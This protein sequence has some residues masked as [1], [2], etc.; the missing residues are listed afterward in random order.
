MNFTDHLREEHAFLRALADKVGQEKPALAAQLGRHAGD[1]DVECLIQGAA[2]LNAG[3]RQR[4]EDGFPEVTQGHLARTWPFPLRPIPA[5]GVVNVSAKA[6]TLDAPL[7]LP[8]GESL[9][10]LSDGRAQVFQTCHAL[11]LQPLALIDRQLLV[12]H[13]HSE[14]RLTFQYQGPGGSWP[15]QP[16]SLFLG[17]DPQ[18]AATLT[19]WCEQHQDRPVLQVEG[20]QWVLETVLSSPRPTA[21]SHRPMATIVGSSRVNSPKVRTYW[22]QNDH[23]GTPHSLTDSQGNTVWRGQYSAYGQ[24]TEE[25]TPPDSR[26]EHPQPKVNNPLR[27]Q[28]QYEDTESG[29]Y[30]NLNR[31]YDPGVGRYLTADPV[32][33]LGGLNGY[34]YVNG[35]PVGWV[36]PLGLFKVDS[37]GF[38][39]VEKLQNDLVEVY[40]VQPIN[41]SS[42]ILLGGAFLDQRLKGRSLLQA[43]RERHRLMRRMTSDDPSV[44][45]NAMQQ[46]QGGRASSPVISTTLDKAGAEA[47]L[48]K[49]GSVGVPAELI[50]IRGPRSGGIDFNLELIQR[51]GRT[52]R[53]GDEDMKEFG[54]KDLY[55][56]AEGKSKSGFEIID[57]VRTKE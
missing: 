43:N 49:L 39:G 48:A 52:K 13:S 46:A 5:C 18:V 31:Y 40:R 9:S 51:G 23:L 54:I 55:V 34:A 47:N 12:T 16:L 32:G 41:N 57:R 14:I 36:D 3:L 25:W 21:D 1:P 15:T 19:L 22:Y 11:T 17:D 6:S 38:E 44:A 35:N 8:A 24:L 10:L 45:V 29:L 37:N 53:F 27:F 26:D 56:P 4:L 33:L 20:R 28:G 50:T 7:T 42:D 2:M 30:Y